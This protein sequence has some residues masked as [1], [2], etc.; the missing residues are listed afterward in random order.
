[1]NELLAN[2]YFVYGLLFLAGAAIMVGGTIFLLNPPLGKSLAQSESAKEE[3]HEPDVSPAD[4][5]R[6]LAEVIMGWH[7]NSP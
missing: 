4:L 1:M 2:E 5:N 7:F 6:Y 3:G